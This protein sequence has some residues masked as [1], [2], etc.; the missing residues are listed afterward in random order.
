MIFHGIPRYVLLFNWI[1]IA[2]WCKI[3]KKYPYKSLTLRLFD[4]IEYSCRVAVLLVMHEKGKEHGEAND[5]F[6]QM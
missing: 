2:L 3:C 4:T 6:V 5:I 1:L